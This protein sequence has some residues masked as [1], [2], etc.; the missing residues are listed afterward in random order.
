MG[1]LG[2]QRVIARHSI[3]AQAAKLADLFRA[4][5]HAPRLAAVKPRDAR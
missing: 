1:K 4:T 2:R 5:S 3:D